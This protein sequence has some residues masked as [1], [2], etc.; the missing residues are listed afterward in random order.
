MSEKKHFKCDVCG[1]AI[2]EGHQELWMTTVVINHREQENDGSAAGHIDIKT[3]YHVH[4]DLS[5]H[6]MGKLWDILK[7]S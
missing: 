4:N 5:N 7:A 6:C 1:H 2:T 3:I